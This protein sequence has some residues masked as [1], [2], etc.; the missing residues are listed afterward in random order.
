MSVKM[1]RSLVFIV[2]I[3]VV[4]LHSWLWCNCPVFI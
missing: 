3:V 2:I 1:E 4:F